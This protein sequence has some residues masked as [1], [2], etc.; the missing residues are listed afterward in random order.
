MHPFIKYITIA[1]LLT[2]CA[3][4]TEVVKYGRHYQKHKDFKSLSKAVELMP[5][6]LTTKQ[7]KKILG[8]PY[9][10]NGF[11]YRYLVDSTGAN[12]CNVGAVFTIDNQGKIKQKWVDEI[13][14]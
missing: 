5:K 8:K 7:V 2:C 6:E 12:N 14:E 13:C 10:D 9:I 11:D 4:K 1:G 3:P